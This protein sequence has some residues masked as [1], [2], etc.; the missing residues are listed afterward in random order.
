M[1]LGA[2]G[3][4]GDADRGYTQERLDE[5]VAE[6]CADLTMMV[7]RLARALKASGSATALADEALDLLE[8]KGLSG[9]P[10]RNG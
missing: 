4:D 5:I 10:L 7:R 2:W 6:E 1:S 3:D 9:N 8:R